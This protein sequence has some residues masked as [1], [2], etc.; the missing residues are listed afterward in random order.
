MTSVICLSVSACCGVARSKRLIN[1]RHR[2]RRPRNA[3]NTTAFGESST[4]AGLVVAGVVAG[5]RAAVGRVAACVAAT[6]FAPSLHVV[7]TNR[8]QRH[9][10]AP[11]ASGSRIFMRFIIRIAPSAIAAV[12]VPAAAAAPDAISMPRPS[13]P[14]RGD[15]ACVSSPADNASADMSGRRAPGQLTKFLHCPVGALCAASSL[16]PS[17]AAISG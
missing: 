3:A 13:H 16:T 5:T 4:R 6:V 1:R 2:P 15:A 11:A 9:D 10:A 8:Q 14:R 17:A 7:S 12:G